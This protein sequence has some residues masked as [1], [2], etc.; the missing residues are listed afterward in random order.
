VNLE[1]AVEAKLQANA[2]KYPIALARG[3]ATKASRRR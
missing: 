3:N 1:V 2:H